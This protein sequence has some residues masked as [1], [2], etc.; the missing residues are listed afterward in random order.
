MGAYYWGTEHSVEDWLFAEGNRFDFHQAV[1]LL[2]LIYPQK[3]Q[4]GEYLDP[5]REVVRFRSSPILDFPGTDVATVT[6]ARN[7]EPAEIVVNFLGLAGS[8]GPFPLSYTELLLDRAARKDTTLRDF[9]DLFNHRLVSLAYRARK[10]HR[11]GLETMSP[12]RSA[13]A[14]YLF[15]FL[16]L[17]TEGLKGRMEVEDRSLLYFAGLF[18]QQ[19]RSMTGLEA[20]LEAFFDLDVHGEQLRG[21]WLRIEDDER[22][23][24]GRNGRNNALGEGVVLGGRFWDQCR[25]FELHLG[26]IAFERLDEFL[27]DGT[28]HAALRALV[29]FYAGTDYDLALVLVVDRSTVPPLRLDGRTRLGWT[30]WLGAGTGDSLSVRLTSHPSQTFTEN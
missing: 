19:S 3:A 5:A 17:G 22:T 14:P 2:E 4:V 18:V 29:S 6:P 15:S 24:I 12:E 30:T 13:F 11:I 21:G 10:L 28:A 1:R 25:G 20:L 23:V 16:G 7:G 26:P 8:H 27:P 9:L